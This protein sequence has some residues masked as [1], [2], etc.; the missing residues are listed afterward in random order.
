MMF[1]EIILTT[2]FLFR[3][4]H[5]AGGLNGCLLCKPGDLCSIFGTHERVE[6]ENRPLKVVLRPPNGIHASPTIIKI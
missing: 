3:L 6:G 2:V 4:K 1:S 5:L